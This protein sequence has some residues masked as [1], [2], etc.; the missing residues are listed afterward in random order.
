MMIYNFQPFLFRPLP[1]HSNDHSFI[2]LLSRLLARIYCSDLPAHLWWCNALGT[3]FNLHNKTSIKLNVLIISDCDDY[4]D[5][6]RLHSHLRQ[7]WFVQP[8]RIDSWDTRS[9]CVAKTVRH[10]AG[11]KSNLDGELRKGSQHVCRIIIWPSYV[12]CDN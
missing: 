8:E 7:L 5:Q 4:Y 6:R 2:R 11:Q 12:D 3:Q 9:P 1:H 10:V